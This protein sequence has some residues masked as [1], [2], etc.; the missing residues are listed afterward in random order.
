MSRTNRTARAPRAA[1]VVRAP[2][3][4]LL[5]LFVGATLAALWLMGAAPAQAETAPGPLGLT[6]GTV[7]DTDLPDGLD[8]PPSLEGVAEVTAPVTDTL[9]T[10]QRRLEQR[11]E[12]APTG[13]LS[14]PSVTEVGVSVRDGA[15]RV[16]GEL[17]VVDRDRAENLV[18]HVASTK[19]LTAPTAAPAAAERSA[20]VETAPV[21]ERDE[22]PDE[23]SARETDAVDVPGSVFAVHLPSHTGHPVG[24]VAGA[25]TVDTE[26]PAPAD[27]DHPTAPKPTTGSSAPSG[28]A[29]PGVAGYLTGSHIAAPPA[30]VPLSA[31]DAV[32]PV[33]A[34]ATDD[35]TVSPD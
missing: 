7:L 30:D 19:P 24:A 16:V 17:E 11:A 25:G 27:P 9:G 15:R 32:H 29:A 20:T 14:D 21:V 6:Q 2:F 35:L 23:G 28:A 10:V 33:P 18:A 26:R 12:S 1:T 3:P 13:V 8:G 4:L 5:P 34:G 22:R 31:V